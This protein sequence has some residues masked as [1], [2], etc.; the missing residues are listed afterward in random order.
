M[1][2]NVVGTNVSPLAI[3]RYLEMQVEAS[4]HKQ[5]RQ[6]QEYM[7]NSVRGWSCSKQKLWCGNT[8]SHDTKLS[9]VM[10][11]GKGGGGVGR[12]LGPQLRMSHRHP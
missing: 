2:P 11:V 10:G 4:K 1:P 6:A 7:S 5:H 8:G 3:L 12:D 9:V